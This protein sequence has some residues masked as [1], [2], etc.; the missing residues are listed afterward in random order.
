MQNFLEFAYFYI[1]EKAIVTV[2]SILHLI[3]VRK[4]YYPGALIGFHVE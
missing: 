4:S 1:F 3:H 2:V